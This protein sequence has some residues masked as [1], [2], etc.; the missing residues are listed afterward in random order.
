MQLKP[1]TIDDRDLFY[2]YYKSNP[3]KCSYLSFANLFLWKD[4]EDIHF[5]EYEGHLVVT[6]KSLYHGERYFMM[7]LGGCL[8][9][10]L[11]QYLD[12]NFKNKYHIYGITHLDVESVRKNCGEFFQIERVRDMDNYVY[13]SEKLISL[14][15]KKLHG[16]RNHIN[17][18]KELYSYQ[19]EPL[20]VD[21]IDKIRPFV[22]EWYQQKAQT[23]ASIL[24][25]KTALEN[26]LKYFM[27]LELKGGMLLVDGKVVAFSIGEQLNSDTALIHFE[28][29]DTN[30]QGAYP[31]INQ[32]FVQHEWSHLTYINREDDMGIE[33][34]RKA[35]LSYQPDVMVEMYAAVPK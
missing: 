15:G 34:L 21:S 13:L 22:E 1:L 6:G 4:A 16:K 23:D 14:S 18:F 9:G 2:Q 5:F 8:C 27:E 29:A 19:Y 33:G 17:K 28:K 3:A 7:P 10:K 35:K 26:A 32:Q 12:E 31:M 24:M 25:E 30:Y 11:K 20:T